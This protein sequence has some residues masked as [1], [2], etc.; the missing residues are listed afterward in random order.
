MQ[1]SR[2][3]ELE[4]EREMLQRQVEQAST[5]QQR[6]QE[7]MSGYQARIEA[8]PRRESELVEL[9]R[10]YETLRS[11]Y[12]SL[13]EKREDARIAESLERRQIGEQFKVLDPANLPVGPIRPDRLRIDA[14]GALAGLA[15]GVGLVG[16]V[17]YRDRSLK[18]EADVVGALSVPVLTVI[19]ALPSA[20]ERVR[21]RLGGWALSL[22]GSAVVVGCVGIVVL[23]LLP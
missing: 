19:P 20:R 14:T 5:E 9:T 1:Q 8:M 22:V 3:R 10:D 18:T 12:E 21:R 13:L 16:L 4:A 11:M 2:R 6:L 7:Q 23:T 15:L 17:E